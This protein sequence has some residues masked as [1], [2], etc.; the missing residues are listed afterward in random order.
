MNNCLDEKHE[1]II[2]LLNHSGLLYKGLP[3]WEDVDLGFHSDNIL[4]ASAIMNETIQSCNK[5]EFL[6]V[7]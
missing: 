4:N 5:T 7:G 3:D 1:Q 2:R 6:E